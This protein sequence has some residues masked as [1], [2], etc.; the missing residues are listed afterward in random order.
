MNRKLANGKLL[1]GPPELV[2]LDRLSP[3][4]HIGHQQVFTIGN[5]IY[6]LSVR[7]KHKIIIIIP[8]ISSILIVFN[9]IKIE[10]ISVFLTDYFLVTVVDSCFITRF[11]V[12]SSTCILIA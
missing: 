7:V 12:I 1:S 11:H 6:W 4:Q 9:S 8:S 3:D 10:E 2:L 5:T